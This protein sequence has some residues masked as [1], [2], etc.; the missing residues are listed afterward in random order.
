MYQT[1][2]VIFPF[3]FLSHFTRYSVFF[4]PAAVPFLHVS[5]YTV[6]S[7]TQYTMASSGSNEVDRYIAAFPKE[8]QTAME[9][10]RTTIRKAAPE[11]EE[12]ISYKMPAY[13]YH[14]MLVYFAGYKN[15]IGFY[16]TP[17]GHAAF[18]KELSKY[19]EGKGS[20]QFPL[21]EPMPLAL[22]AKIV[23]FRIKENRQ[24]EKAKA[25]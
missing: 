8:A 16:A 13:K 24:R 18:Q 2:S 17:T 23:K 10:V 21:D 3:L 14:G 12:L 6:Q 19:K 7:Q 20:V 15:H 22:I 4:V 11:A 25:R 1:G 5:L 9:Q